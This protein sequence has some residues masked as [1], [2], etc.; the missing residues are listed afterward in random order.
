MTDSKGVGM[1]DDTSLR[2]KVRQILREDKDLRGYGLNAD[3][4]AGEVQLQGI[5][6]TL[7]E[8]ERAERLVRQVPGVKG[9]ANAVAISTDGAIRD[10][11]VTMEVHEELDLDPRVDLRHIGA[12]SVDGHGTVVLKGRAEEPVE[13]EAAREAAAKARG[14]TRVVSQVK[15]GEEEMS[16]EDIFHRQ[17]NNDREE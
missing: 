17:V 7:K 16:L 8:K 9:V 13:V 1:M 4:V 6:D 14:V 11:D 5:V 3:V 10:E 12:E 15:V 2:E